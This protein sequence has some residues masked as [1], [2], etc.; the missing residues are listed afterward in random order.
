MRAIEYKHVLKP[1]IEYLERCGSLMLDTAGMA[2]FLG[3][4]T[5]TLAQLVYT[6]RIPLPCRLGLGKCQRWS[7]LELLEWV[8]AACPRRGAW[9]EMRGSSGWCPQWRW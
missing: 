4:P 3:V 9:I 5:K 1:S 8:E 2:E 6:D 7:V